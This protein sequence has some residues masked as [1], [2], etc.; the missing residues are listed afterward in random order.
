MADLER[1]L[2]ARHPDNF[3]KHPMMIA[4]AAVIIEEGKRLLVRDAHGFWSGVG[5]WVDEGERPDEAVLREVK[6]E[7]GVEGEVTGVLHPH[8]EWKA[9]Q[10]GDG[11][12]FLLF[13]Y[14]VRLLSHEFALQESEVTDLCWVGPADWQDLPMLPYVRALW[15]ERAAEWLG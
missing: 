5:G 7:L 12:G 1:A 3:R 13:L 11:S 15:I 8:L 6:E 2:E 4:C 14:R 9:F 10:A